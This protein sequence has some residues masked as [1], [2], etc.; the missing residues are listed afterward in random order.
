LLDRKKIHLSCQ[1]SQKLKNI[2]EPLAC[3]PELAFQSC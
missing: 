3:L 2:L 1:Q